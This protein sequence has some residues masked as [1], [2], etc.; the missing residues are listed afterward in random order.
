[1]KSLIIY[2]T[3]YGSAAE[4]ARRIQKEIG[5]DCTAVNITSENVPPL[6]TFDIVILGGSIYIGKAQKEL[7]SFAA[8]NLKQLL[9]KKV[10]LYLCAGA[11][12]Q[13]EC[14]KEL[15]GA[16]QSE[17]YAH[18]MTKAVLGY[19]FSFEKMRFFDRLIMKKIK[20]DAVSTAE[21]FEERISQFAKTLT[22]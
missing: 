14:D 8:A 16:F 4:V 17:L 1:M 13:E 18:A 15:L 3:R 20:G 5:D 22:E 19:A 6:D 21:Y 7:T 10:G 12:K 9:S 11:Q 2:A